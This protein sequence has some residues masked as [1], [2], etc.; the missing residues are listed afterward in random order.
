MSQIPQCFQAYGNE[1]CRGMQLIISTC[2]ERH[3]CTSMLQVVLLGMQFG[4]AVNSSASYSCPTKK[5]TIQDVFHHLVQL[6]FKFNV[7]ANF[8]ISLSFPRQ[9]SPSLHTVR[10]LQQPARSLFCTEFPLGLRSHMQTEFLILTCIQTSRVV[11]LPVTEEKA[12]E[13]AV[14]LEVWHVKGACNK[15]PSCEERLL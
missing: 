2:T 15:L 10:S 4:S 3:H 9:T 11:C 12:H 13:P 7:S 5:H 8:F 6:A 14:V 1:A